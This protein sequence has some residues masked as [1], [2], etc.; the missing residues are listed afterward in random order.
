MQSLCG[1]DW[2]DL[3]HLVICN[4]RKP[5][6][7]KSNSN[8]FR[9]F[10]IKTNSKTWEHVSEFKKGY[11]YNEGNLYEMLKLTGW[12][13]NEVLYFGGKKI[14]LSFNAA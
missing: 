5:D 1:S 4:A 6:F 3:F 12:S 11:I 9:K 2:Q 13:R 8:P 7:F 10:D 14:G